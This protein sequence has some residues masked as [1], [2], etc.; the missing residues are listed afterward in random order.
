[1]LKTIIFGFLLGIVG[2]VA[3]AYYVPVVDQ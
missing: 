1:M 2:T 3:A